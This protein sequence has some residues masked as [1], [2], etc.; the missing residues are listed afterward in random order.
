M[1]VDVCVNAVLHTLREL[2]NLGHRDKGLWGEETFYFV[3]FY[4]LHI[5]YYFF[6]KNSGS[7][8]T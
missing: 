4:S 3:L 1:S 7:P 5:T 6:V 8:S 2:C